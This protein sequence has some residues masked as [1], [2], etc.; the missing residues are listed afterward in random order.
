L[1]FEKSI[2]LG[3]VGIFFFGIALVPEVFHAFEFERTKVRQH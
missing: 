1:G 3:A 2:R